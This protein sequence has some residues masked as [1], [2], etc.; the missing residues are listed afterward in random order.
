MTT[1]A[2]VP[3][4]TC[5]IELPSVFD[6]DKCPWINPD[7]DTVE[8]IIATIKKCPSGALSLYYQW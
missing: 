5:Y 3:P 6:M 2:P 4:G 7:G 1:A 8:N